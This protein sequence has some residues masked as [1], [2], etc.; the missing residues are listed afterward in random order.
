MNRLL[1]ALLIVLPLSQPVLAAEDPVTHNR[2]YIGAEAGKETYRAIYQ[3]DSNHPEIIKKAI[4]NINNLLEDPRLKGK[5]QVELV[6]FAGGTEALMKSS[7]YEKEFRALVDKG[8]LVVQ[9]L[10]SLKERKLDKSQLFD[11]IGYVPSGNGE[12]VIRGADD[13]VIIKP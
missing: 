1:F 13:W 11:F 9:C 6:A 2:A 10:N 12:L 4:R 7:A 5:V 8:V 3:L